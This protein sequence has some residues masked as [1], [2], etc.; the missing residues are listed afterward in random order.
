VLQR[1]TTI[2]VVLLFGGMIA[3]CGEDDALTTP[4][5]QSSAGQA[6][7][8]QGS[9]QAGATPGMMSWTSPPEMQLEEGVDY[10]AVIRTSLGEMTID[11][12]EEEA[13]L[14]VNNFIFLARQGFYEG[15]P[16]HRVINGFMIQ[17]GDPTGTGSGGPGYRFA[18]E[19]VN[20]EYLRGTVAM[21]NSGPNTNGSQFFIMHADRPLQ[22]NY[23]IFGIVTEGVETLN[24]IAN[25]EVSMN[26]MGEMA[27]PVDPVVIERVEIVQR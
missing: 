25:V 13:P 19:P 21:A 26:A 23:T 22:P 10:G 17:T 11:L 5:G 2:L 24:A 18:D 4:A 16:F 27:S 3:A 7:P 9:G 20:R 8:A 6:T 14:T 12:F 15:V 1:L